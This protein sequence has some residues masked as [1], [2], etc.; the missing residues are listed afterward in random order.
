[1][2]TTNVSAAER[3]KELQYELEER[4]RRTED[5]QLQLSRV[6]GSVTE[7]RLECERLRDT[8]KL[9]SNEKHSLQREVQQLQSKLSAMEIN[10]ERRER[11][12]L[13]RIQQ[14]QKEK[15]N[16]SQKSLSRDEKS[17]TLPDQT[18]LQVLSSISNIEKRLTRMDVD[19]SKAQVL[20]RRLR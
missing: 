4:N 7:L 15:E 9:E 6:Q 18:R 13:D 19:M 16:F 20:I 5:A 8:L 1:M 17:D 10:H 12:L 3:V 2:F 14:L 11:E